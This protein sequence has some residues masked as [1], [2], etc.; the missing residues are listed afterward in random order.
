MKISRVPPLAHF[1]TQFSGL[2]GDLE[3][4]RTAR[5]VGMYQ[6]IECR[7]VAVDCLVAGVSHVIFELSPG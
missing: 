6:V 4:M 7:L 3:F 1:W 2:G 5:M